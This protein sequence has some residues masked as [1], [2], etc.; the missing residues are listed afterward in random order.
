MNSEKLKHL[1]SLHGVTQKQVAAYLG[2][3]VNNEP[4]RSMIARFENGY[5]PINPRVALALD[6]YFSSFD[7]KNA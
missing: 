2:Y 1:R 6:A 7:A 5:A 4:N 3:T